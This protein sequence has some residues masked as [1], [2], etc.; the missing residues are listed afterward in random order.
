ME[1]FEAHPNRVIPT[2]EIVDWATKTWTDRTGKVFRDPDRG[3]RRLSQSGKLI[4]HSKGEYSFHPGEIRSVEISY[5]SEKLKQRVKER[6]GFKCVVC[7]RGEEHGS[8]LHVDHI[9]PIDKGGKA[10]FENGQ[11]LC[12]QHNFLKKNTHGTE[13]AKKFFIRHY[14]LA[15]SKG[16]VEIADFCAEV[17]KLYEKFG[18][19]DHINWKPTD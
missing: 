2:E 18:I 16:M 7:G 3:I 10:T 9:L 19:D 4:K 1:Y 13:F 14:D 11:T 17:I 5:F 12:S 6:D 15:R 8:E